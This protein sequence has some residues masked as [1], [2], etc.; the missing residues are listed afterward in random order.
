MPR[1]IDFQHLQKFKCRFEVVSTRT[2]KSKE[3][4]A[5]PLVFRV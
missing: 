4:E 5:L 3:F 1:R 2:L